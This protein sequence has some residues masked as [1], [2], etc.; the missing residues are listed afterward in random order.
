MG[1]RESV[2]EGL[3]RVIVRSRPGVRF[4]NSV[5]SLSH[6]RAGTTALSN[7]LCS[8]PAISGYGEAHIRYDSEVALGRLVVNHT[9]RGQHK[10]GATYLHDKILHDRYTSPTTCRFFASRAI[11]I[12][13]EPLATVESIRRLFAA[14]GGDEYPDDL[15]AAQYYVDRIGHLL[16]LWNRFPESQ[17][18]AFRAEEVLGSPDRVLGRLSSFLRLS[19]P[20][21][22]SYVSSTASRREG[23]GDPL[24]SGRH[25]RILPGSPKPPQSVDVSLPGWM[26]DAV[27]DAHVRAV[28][29]FGC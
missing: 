18:I 25:S 23:A 24:V 20:L 1:V 3:G 12:V 13:R 26:V 11:F 5:F 7:V 8:H 28:T 22:N 21:V 2:K 14:V 19:A 27:C 4:E 17:R 29:A 9:V 6:M 10:A 15:S 16:D